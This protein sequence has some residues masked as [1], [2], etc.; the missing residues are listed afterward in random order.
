MDGQGAAVPVDGP[1]PFPAGLVAGLEF[2]DFEAMAAAARGWDQR[3]LK[4]APGPFHG[5]IAMAHTSRMQL[6]VAEWSCGLLSVGS[7]PKGVR[8]FA[9]VSGPGGP[10]RHGGEPVRPDQLATLSDRGE[11]HFLHPHSCDMLVFS[12]ASDLLEEMAAT[13]LGES[14]D[15][16]AGSATVLDLRDPCR[17]HTRLSQLQAAAIAAD[18]ARLRDPAFAGMLEAAA[19]EALLPQLDL[20]PRRVAAAER[21]RLGRRAEDYLRAHQGRPVT[22]AELCAAVGAPERTLHMACRDY[23]GLPPIAF[24]RVLRLHG[25]RRQLLELGP[26]TSVTETAADW[27]FFHFGEFAAAY[28]RLF[29]EAPSRTKRRAAQGLRPDPVAVWNGI[30]SPTARN[31]G[32]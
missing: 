3:Y 29:G 18:P 25:V 12:L 32:P 6:A 9:L 17:V 14:W 15:E 7:V 24:L 30:T 20:P 1:T 13:Y 31:T 11:L 19:A 22:I 4:L 26:A 10:A 28:R 5:A 8:T 23:F 16:A 21:R 27:G 2:A